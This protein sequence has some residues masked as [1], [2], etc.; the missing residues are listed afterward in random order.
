MRIDWIGNFFKC[1]YFG[2]LLLRNPSLSGSILI[3]RLSL[4]LSNNSLGNFRENVRVIL[5]QFSRTGRSNFIIF[6]TLIHLFEF[7][8][9]VFFVIRV[10]LFIWTLV[11]L[12]IIT[13]L[14]PTLMETKNLIF[15]IIIFVLLF[16][17]LDRVWRSHRGIKEI[18]YAFLWELLELL[19]DTVL[20]HHIEFC[21]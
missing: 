14:L 13:K 9:L 8:F 1:F 6:W 18:F 7:F 5:N 16:L 17:L 3:F 10:V 2:F 19:N 11:F 15:F 20:V 4:D 12:N 21:L